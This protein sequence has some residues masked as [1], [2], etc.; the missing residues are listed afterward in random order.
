MTWSVE[1]GNGTV[2]PKT[3]LVTCTG[4]GDIKVVAVTANGRKGSLIIKGPREATSVSIKKSSYT[5]S[6][7]ESCQPIATVSPN[8]VIYSNVA[9][10]SEKPEIATVAEDGTITAVAPGRTTI[11]ATA[12]NGKQGRCTVTV[13]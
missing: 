9:W 11:Y 3:G 10:T 5:L 6:V 2:D 7:G 12:Y 13:K 4:A 1:K 8:G